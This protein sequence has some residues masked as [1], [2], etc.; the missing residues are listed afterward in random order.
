MNKFLGILLVGVIGLVYAGPGDAGA[1]FLKIP[2]DARVVGLGEASA[3]YIDNASALYYNPAG[4]GKISTVDLLFM[5]NEWLLGMNHEY[6]ASAFNLKK[7]GT[8]GISFNYWG[9]GEIQGVTIR[10]DT[11]PG[12]YFSASDWTFN[13]GYGRD[14]RDFSLGIGFKFL[15]EHN[16]SLSASAIGF[17]FG[18]MYKPPV[19]GLETGLSITNIGTSLKLDQESFPLPILVRLGWKYRLQNLGF[20]Q[21]FI[22][23]NG[24]KFGIALGAEY[25]IAEIMALRLGYKT[26]SDVA[27][28]S[29]LRTGLGILIRGF[30]LDYAFAPYGK[31]SLTHRFS[32]SFKLMK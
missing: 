15:S 20:A 9:S 25:L 30:G 7:I 31:L 8:F 5:H 2:V 1:A 18:G 22:F 14:F 4:L 16:E 11:I 27:G 19:K 3:G 12:Y 21:D 13:I 10:G 29:G 6:L 26:G 28:I 32:I 17:D 24:D 23:S